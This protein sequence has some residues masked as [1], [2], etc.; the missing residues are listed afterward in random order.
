MISPRSA[1]SLTLLAAL[2]GGL[3]AVANRA[4]AHEAAADASFP[5]VGEIIMVD[6]LRVHAFV[7]GAGPDLVL[8]HGASGNLREFTFSLI[9]QLTD[10]YRVIAFDRPGLGW[11]DPLPDAADS[12]AQQ[13]AHLRRAAAQLNLAN[14][15]V[16]GHSY[17]GAVALAWALDAADTQALVLVSAASMPWEGSIW[18]MHNVMGNAIG[19][20]TVVPLITAFA[21]DAT[22]ENAVRGIFAPNAMPDGYLAH[23]GAPLTM[24]RASLHANSAQVAELK[25]HI[26][27]QSNLYGSLTLPVELIHGDTDTIVPHHIHSIPL[28]RVLQ[29]AK[30]TILPGTGHMPQ[31]ANEPAVIAAIDRAAARAGLR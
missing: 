3:Y 28:S 19:A 12:P 5:P 2:A 18:F 24:R 4:S 27:V 31:H 25:P 1:L 16:L 17:G 6:G 13:A 14:P 23:I 11:S 15:I 7:A 8:I 29:N 10:R 21:S 30:L 9:P 22:A 20:R 26:I